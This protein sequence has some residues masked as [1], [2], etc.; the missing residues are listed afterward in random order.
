MDYNWIEKYKPKKLNEIIGDKSTIDTVNNF[1]K[2]FAK[3]DFEPSKISTPNLIIIGSNGIGKTLL[4]DTAIKENGFEKVTINLANVSVGKKPKRA[5]DKAGQ[6]SAEN[7]YTTLMSDNQLTING[8]YSKRKIVLVFDDITSIS[9]SNE[10][11]TIKAITKCNVKFKKFPIIIIANLKHSRTVND[12]KKYAYYMIKGVEDGVKKNKKVFNEIK[13]QPPSC[14]DIENF[15]MMIARKEKLNIVRR[16]KD[17]IDIYTKIIEHAQY[18][19]RRLVMTLEELKLVFGN[20]SITVDTFEKYQITAVKK[21]MDP[22]IYDATYDLLNNY[23]GINEALHIYSEERAAIPLMVHENFPTNIK[24]QYPHMNQKQKIDLI[25]R[26]SNYMS[27]ADKVDGLIYSNQNWSLQTVHGYYSCVLTSYYINEDEDKRRDMEK[28]IYTQDYN[29]TSIKK[30]NNKV[31]KKAQEHPVFKRVSIY[32]FLYIASILR[33]LFERR[34]FERL[35][36]LM[37]PYNLKLK[38]IESIIKIDKIQKSKSALTGKQ[39]TTL[40]EL[41]GVSE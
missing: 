3:P 1:I 14:N 32:N 6:K 25:A 11:A 41:L 33:E 4:V 21:D 10:K 30:I 7:Y 5:E 13:I 37:K 9:N 28:Y 16:N 15:I 8:S 40:K 17:E 38:E 24:V 18:D 20:S 2:Q 27:I 39:K 19:I 26:I 23:R 22:G 29:K 36:Q 34:D 35:A 12:L 31:I